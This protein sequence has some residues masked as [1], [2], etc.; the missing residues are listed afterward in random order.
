M[1]QLCNYACMSNELS[2][3]QRRA[4]KG[5]NARAASLSLERKKAIGRLAAEAR[6]SG[7]LPRA[8]HDGPLQIGDATLVAAVLPNGK[9][10][11]VQ[12]TMLTAI[13]RSRT[14]KAGTGGTV[15][16]DG[17]PFFL[18]AEVLKPFITDE[19]RLSTTPIF[20]RL[21]SGQRAVGYDALLLPRVCKVY[22]T[23]RD[24]LMQRAF[25]RSTNISS[26]DVMN[27]RMDLVSAELR[28]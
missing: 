9:R 14:P 24:S 3:E 23:L 10:L 12:G 5:G 27:W 17:L 6:W 18:S 21:K 20:F 2:A 1:L 22:Q 11:I 26:P 15:N 25:M 19:L 4:A 13:G 16:V 8:S 7:D 28:P